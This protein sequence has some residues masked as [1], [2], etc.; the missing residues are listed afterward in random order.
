MSDATSKG[1][2][3]GRRSH[4]VWRL[5]WFALLISSAIITYGLVVFG[6]K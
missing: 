2:A 4:M 6:G 5:G 3:A 1:L